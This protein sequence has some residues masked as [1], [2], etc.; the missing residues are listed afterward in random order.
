[1]EGRSTFVITHRISTAMRADRILV[2]DNGRMAGWGVHDDLLSE[3]EVYRLLYEQQQKQK[4]E[5]ADS[6]Y[7]RD[8]GDGGAKVRDN[9]NLIFY[10]P[11]VMRYIASK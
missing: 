3:S 11:D 4:E 5:V 9:T 2:L 6:L 7:R 1:M 8:Y 10:C